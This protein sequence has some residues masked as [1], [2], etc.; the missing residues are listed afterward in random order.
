MSFLISRVHYL[1]L[2]FCLCVA[3][4]SVA[5]ETPLGVSGATTIN[6]FKAKEL[7]DRGA[8]F[9][10]VR[11]NDEWTIGHID[12]AIHLD[13]QKD[14]A[15]LYSSKLVNRDTPIVIYCN[16][17]NCL[18]SAYAVAVSVHWGFSNVYYFREGYFA[19]ILEDYPSIMSNM[20]RN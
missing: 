5:N 10:D 17:S 13:F 6:V 16:S 3:F 8:V 20:A 14:F 19:W 12:G 18:R 15:K 4:P 9:I 7:Y 11:N 2:F 1:F